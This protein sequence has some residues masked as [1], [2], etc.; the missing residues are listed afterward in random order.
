MATNLSN[1]AN[2]RYSFSSGSGSAVSNTT[3]TTLIDAFSLTAE[4]ISLTGVFRPGEN[5]GYVL[6]IE[7][8][9]SGEIYAVQV[10]DD[11]GAGETGAAP[12]SYVADSA[13]LTV[14]G[15][16]FP[17]TP[18]LEDG[19][20]VFALPAALAPGDVAIITYLARVSPAIGFGTQQITNTASVSGRAGSP[21][22]EAVTVSPAPSAT[23]DAEA[24]AEVSI[25]KEAD[26]SAVNSGEMLTYT[27]TLTNTGNEAAQGVVLT[28]DLPDGFTVASV[29]SVGG[30]EVTTYSAADFLV[31]PV[32]NELTFP[33]PSSAVAL[34]VPAADAFGPGV[35][36][37]I[38]TGSVG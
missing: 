30:G 20:L 32:T 28:D 33:A 16:V 8:N 14:N 19:A 7:N 10:G 23:V 29:A 3:T 34:T 4:K 15:S 38:V 12:L 25:L 27:F 9:G 17:I 31:D 11:L 13:L 26:K 5:L 36:T 22:G 6:R 21:A 24:Y 2:I 1:Q 35:E 18:Q 37:I